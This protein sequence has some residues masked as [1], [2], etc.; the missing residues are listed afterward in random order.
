[1]AER[2]GEADKWANMR[3]DV[4]LTSAG[5]PIEEIVAIHPPK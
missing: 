5:E 1:M 2:K 4:T 3:N